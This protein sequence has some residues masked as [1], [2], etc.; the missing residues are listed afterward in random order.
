MKDVIFLVV[1]IAYV[2][3]VFSIGVV[4][5]PIKAVSVL[6]EGFVDFIT[7]LKD[8]F[9]DWLYGENTN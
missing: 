6:M 3:L 2:V 5:V 4:A 7:D 1:S 9:E 8:S